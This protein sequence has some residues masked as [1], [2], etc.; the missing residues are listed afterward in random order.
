MA[1]AKRYEASRT[2]KRIRKANPARRRQRFERAYLSSAYVGFIRWTGCVV[3]GCTR[4]PVRACH[5]VSRGAGG[6]WRDLFGGCDEHHSEQHAVGNREFE[7]RHGL[8]LAAACD[9]L[10]MEWMITTKGAV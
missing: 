4:T 8:D 9:R 2:R 6:T 10:V 7:R 5:R 1:A 3:R